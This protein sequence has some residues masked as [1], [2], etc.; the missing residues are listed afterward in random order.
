M[1]VP[2]GERG[3]VQTGGGDRV[4]TISLLG[5]STSMALSTGPTDKEDNIYRG[6]LD[7]K[8]HISSFGTR[9][10]MKS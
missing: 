1:G 6:I 7:E 2:G 3:N 5:C 4:S 8:E 9:I 10:K